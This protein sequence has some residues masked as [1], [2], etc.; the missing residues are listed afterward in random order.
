MFVDHGGVVEPDLSVRAWFDTLLHAHVMRTV[1]L[2]CESTETLVLKMTPQRVGPLFRSRMESA[3]GGVPGAEHALVG[4][5]R[6]GI[7]E[8]S[9]DVTLSPDSAV[10]VS[11][12]ARSIS[13]SYPDQFSSG[14]RPGGSRSSYKTARS[15][16]TCIHHQRSPL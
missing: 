2:L 4:K 11:V 10:L 1:D 5:A 13:S 6:S 16:T 7:R 8:V 15:F 12:P 14:A 3:E 9:S